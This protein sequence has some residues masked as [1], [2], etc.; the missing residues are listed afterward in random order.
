M[1]GSVAVVLTLVFLASQI[2]QHSRSI[3]AQITHD[4]IESTNQIRASVAA[5]AGL[6]RTWLTG[7][8]GGELSYEDYARFEM[9]VMSWYFLLVDL[10]RQTRSGHLKDSNF[11]G[12]AN[13]VL[14]QARVRRAM[15]VMLAQAPADEF[16]DVLRP[17]VTEPGQGRQP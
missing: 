5:D 17:L 14:A 8:D 9:V 16:A 7:A 10:H 15:A 11:A 12:M 6:S 1:F 3:S 13:A 2:R 4:F